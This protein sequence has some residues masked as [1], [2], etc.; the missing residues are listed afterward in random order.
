MGIRAAKGAA[1]PTTV[2]VVVIGAGACGLCAALAAKE[3]GAEVIVLERDDR[4]SGSTALSTGLIPAALT[5][6]Q[7]SLGIDDSPEQFA[8]DI[9]AKAKGQLDKAMAMAV[10]RASGPTIDWLAERHGVAFRLVEGFLY[11]GHTQ[12]RMHGTPNRTGVE[13]EAALLAAAERSGIDI[14]TNA[15]VTDLFAH[16]DG[17]IAGVSI[18]RPDGA[19]EP[20]GCEALVLA[21]NGFGGNRAMVREYI[22]EI[23]DA[24][25]QGH[26]GNTGEAVRWGLALGATV[27]D[28][29]SYQGHGA[30]A[31]PHG[32]PIVWALLTEG[33]I[34]VNARGER[35]S[36]EVRGYSEQAVDVVS[37]P[38]RIAWNIYDGQREELAL[39]FTD[40]REVKALGGV[41]QA[42]SIEA[43]AEQIGVPPDA[44]ARTVAEAEALR[45][46]GGSD[47]FG[48]NFAGKAPLRAPFLAVK[49]TGA[50]FHT[51]G[52]LVIDAEARVLRPDGRPLPN[53]LAGGGAARGLS[54]PSRW[55]Y[56]SGNGLLTATV[57][58]R[59]AGMNAARMVASQ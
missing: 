22:P 24:D 59:I 21:C 4:P 13:L 44:L 46:A 56:L 16:E 10:A 37:Q 58:G 54:G 7:K 6:L 8:A 50:L 20:L 17:R 29:G 42:A 38:G 18:Q 39:D 49:V 52:G 3:A 55:G 48:R 43:L 28:M 57:L 25:Y 11:P 30:V 9:I 34:Q 14:V 53:L 27:A 32:N 51:Q 5:N 45:A 33:G 15:L 31:H 19:E 26:V 36:N 1:F 23:A 40:Y 47:R 41:R 2:P 12:F 35:F